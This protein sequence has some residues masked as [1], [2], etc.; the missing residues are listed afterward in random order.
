MAVLE[1]HR[2]P[3]TECPLATPIVAGQIANLLSYDE[4]PI[5]TSN[6][7]LI[8]NMRDY[9]KENPAAGWVRSGDTRVLWNGVTEANNPR[10]RTCTGLGDNKYVA[11]ETLRA[12]IQDDFCAAGPSVRLSR[13]YNEGSMED[14]VVSLDFYHPNPDSSVL[15]RDACIRYL[16]EITDGA[17]R[18]RRETQRITKAEVR[19]S[20]EALSTASSRRPCGSRRSVPRRTDMDMAAILHIS[21]FGTRMSCGATVG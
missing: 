21:S 15:G 1:I 3:D 13:R 18:A 20:L 6:G 12:A 8:K 5:D 7:N 10:M 14:V 9:L 16:L 4:I 2:R 19:R 17:T 11:R